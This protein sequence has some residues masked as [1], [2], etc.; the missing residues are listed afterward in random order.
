MISMPQVSVEPAVKLA[1][2]QYNEVR[3]F[4]GKQYD[5]VGKHLDSNPALYE[6]TLVINHIF[7][8][9]TVFAFMKTLPFSLPVSF[10]VMLAPSLLY[11]ASIERF[12]VFRFTLPALAGGTALWAAHAAAISLVAGTAFSSLAAF[13]SAGLGIASLAGYLVFV[14]KTSHE[15]I[16]NY[17]KTSNRKLCCH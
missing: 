6:K 8:A 16:E 12:C 15:D 11:R 14:Y 4:A 17:M 10:G 9:T 13:L 1:E 3:N 2:A 5:K 7:R